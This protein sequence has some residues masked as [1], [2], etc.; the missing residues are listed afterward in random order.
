[1]TFPIKHPIKCHVNTKFDNLEMENIRGVKFFNYIRYKIV[2]KISS[3]FN[4]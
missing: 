4:L 3:Y 1:M 2:K